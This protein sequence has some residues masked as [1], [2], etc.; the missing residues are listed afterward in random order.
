[1]RRDDVLVEDIRAACARIERYIGGIT[2]AQFIADE[3]AQAAVVREIEII[4][5]AASRVSARIRSDHPEVPWS[6]MVDLR[7]FYIHAYHAVVPAKVWR[8]ATSLVRRVHS[9]V[10]SMLFDDDPEDDEADI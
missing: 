8:T 10:T 9:D 1:M 3:M 2:R 5:E 7:N 4:G 6:V